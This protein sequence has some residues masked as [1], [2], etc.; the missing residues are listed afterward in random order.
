MT[1][2]DSLKNIKDT[3][4]VSKSPSTS[5]KSKKL[6]HISKK[7][8]GSKYSTHFGEEYISHQSITRRS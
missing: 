2:V 3:E 6:H 8:D 1:V 4:K 7:K 5:V